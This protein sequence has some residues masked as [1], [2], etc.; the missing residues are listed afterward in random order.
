M[1][2]LT[3]PASAA[4]GTQFTFAIQEAQQLRI[5]PGAAAIRCS[6]GQTAGK[7]KWADNIGD[8]ITLVADAAGDWVATYK[9]GLWTEE[10]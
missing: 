6:A 1:V 7:Y 9:C 4:A 5:D 2:V 8:A 3:L 10:P